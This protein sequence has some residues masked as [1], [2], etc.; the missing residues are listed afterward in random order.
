MLGA[1]LY[2][3]FLDKKDEILAVEEVDSETDD[4]DLSK[5][6]YGIQSL[7]FTVRYH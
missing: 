7:P 6:L 1:G 5:Q 3:V 4:D 2:S